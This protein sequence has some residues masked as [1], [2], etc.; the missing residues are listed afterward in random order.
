LLINLFQKTSFL[1]KVE[2]HIIQ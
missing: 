2:N 1:T